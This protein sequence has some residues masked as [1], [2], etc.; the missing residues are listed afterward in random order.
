MTTTPNLGISHI[1]ATDTGKVGEF[2]T[3]ISEFDSALAGNVQ[4]PALSSLVFNFGAYFPLGALL[5]ILTGA[6][7]ANQTISL[8]ANARP[9]IVIN[10]TTGG[11]SITFEVGSN[12]RTVTI[13]DSNPHLLYSDGQNSVYQVS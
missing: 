8:P 10:Q 13:S 9:F 5:Y 11:H 1:A 2:N 7:A 12:T 4:V 6:L 3:A